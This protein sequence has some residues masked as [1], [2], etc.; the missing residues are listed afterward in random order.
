MTTDFGEL[1]LTARNASV[2]EPV[3]LLRGQQQ[4][5]VDVVAPASS[6][7]ADDGCLVLEDT[8]PALSANGVTMTSGRYR[9]TGVC[10]AGI[11]GKLGIPA[12]YLRRLQAERPG[13]FDANVN[14]WLAGDDRSFL[15]RCLRGSDGGP[16]VARAWL[17]DGYKRIDHLDTLTAVFDG[18]RQIGCGACTVTPRLIAQVR[19]NGMTV[20]RDA[21]RA[22]HLGERMDEGVRW[23]GDTRDRQLAVAAAKARDAVRAFLSPGYAERVVRDLEKQAGH[24]VADAAKTVEV[25]SARPRYTEAQQ[26]AI[27][28]HFIKGGD[29]TA[30]GIMH[31]VT[32]AAQVQADGDTAWDLENSALDALSLAASC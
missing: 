7:R 3:A 2:E 9:T 24:P 19:A 23:S 15:L 18:I 25:I 13:L 22:V 8:V 4:R 16:G 1:G 29:L 27:L 31:A 17:S 11:A 14:G 5:K 32:S 6:I 10:D 21:V 30:G 28:D 20:T 12:A 26:S